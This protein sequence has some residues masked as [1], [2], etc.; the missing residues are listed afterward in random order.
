MDLWCSAWGYEPLAEIGEGAYGKVF[1]ARDLKNEGRFVALKKVNVCSSEDGVP[2]SLIREVALLKK[3]EFLDNPNVV[4]LFEVCIKQH[5]LK[6]ELMLVLE[7]IDQDLSSFLLKVPEEGLPHDKIKDLMGQVL[8]GIDFLHSNCVIHR[9]LKPE[10]IL[11]S[12]S[13]K[14]KL[15]DFGLSRIYSFH[16]A[17]TPVV[18]TLWYRAPEV[19]LYS[20]YKPSVDIWSFGCVFAEMHQRRSLFLADLNF[21]V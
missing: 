20:S 13:G 1:K 15:A 9:D 7:Y 8:N 10:N 4:R 6:V 3:F 5:D 16:M 18:V 12:S 17:L 11:I 21:Q 14:I 2:G 19:L